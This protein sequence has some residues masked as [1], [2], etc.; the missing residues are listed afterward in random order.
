MLDQHDVKNLLLGLLFLFALFQHGLMFNMSFVVFPTSS[1]DIHVS[2][3]FTYTYW[4]VT[5]LQIVN[6]TIRR[7]VYCMCIII[8]HIKV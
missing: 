5:Y 2:N 4:Q 1:K 3:I 6:V 8:Q 7:L